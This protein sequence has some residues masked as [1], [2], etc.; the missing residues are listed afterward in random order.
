M[1]LFLA[2]GLAAWLCK[3]PALGL[4]LRVPTISQRGAG[5]S[6]LYVG[7]G[8]RGVR[9]VATAVAGCP[10]P[11]PCSCH[12]SCPEVI[13]ALPPSTTTMPDL[14]AIP[15]PTQ[16]DAAAA[17]VSAV[18]GDEIQTAGK[19]GRNSGGRMRQPPMQPS[20]PDWQE[21]PCPETP[22]CNCYC[23]CGPPPGFDSTAAEHV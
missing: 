13:F 11:Q 17:P 14:W 6:F 3:T 9:H 5:D 23:H 2:I 10:P 4:E 22:P 16:P 8:R 12:C 15:L 19:L 21:A 7:G 20:R 18:H 1:K